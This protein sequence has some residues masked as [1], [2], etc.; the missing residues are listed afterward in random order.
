MVDMSTVTKECYLDFVRRILEHYEVDFPNRIAQEFPFNAQSLGGFVGYIINAWTQMYRITGN[1]SHA[2]KARELL[3]Y[4]SRYPAHNPPG[5]KTKLS[6][7][8]FV[9][10]MLVGG[11][12]ILRDSGFVTAEEEAPVWSCIYDMVNSLVDPYVKQGKEKVAERSHA[13]NHPTMDMTLAVETAQ[14]FP[15][16]PDASKWMEWGRFVLD[17]SFNKPP[18][19]DV[20]G[21]SATWFIHTI[22]AAELLGLTQDFYA[23]PYTRYY[24]Q[25]FRDLLAPTGQ[26]P[27]FGDTSI[28]GDWSKNVA[29]LEKAAS[30]YRDGS[31]KTAAHRLFQYM[32]PYGPVFG[33][34]LNYVPSEEKLNWDRKVA[35]EMRAAGGYLAQ[36]SGPPDPREFYS[37][38]N[39]TSWRSTYGGTL[40]TNFSLLAY[41][42]ADDSVA[43]APIPVRDVLYERRAVLRDGW[44]P[45][46][47]YLCY[48]LEDWTRV[49]GHGEGN[50]VNLLCKWGSMLLHE[51]E[52][53]WKQERYHN[54]VI[55]K[56][57]ISDS[58]LDYI[59][60]PDAPF[61]VLKVRP[62]ERRARVPVF[63]P[64]RDAVFLRS[65]LDQFQ[66]TL[67]KAGE[68]VY[69]FDYLDVKG[70]YTAACL[71]HTQKIVEQ[72]GNAYRTRI[73]DFIW[74][75]R[76][77]RYQNPGEGELLIIF[78]K[79]TDTGF[80]KE[81]RA[82]M[83]E[84]AVY[85]LASD[86]FPQGLAFSTVLFPVKRADPAMHVALNTETLKPQSS[87]S[88]SYPGADGVRLRLNGKTVIVCCK[89]VDSIGVV[90]YGD[91]E[92]DADVLYLKADSGKL[93]ASA[94]NVSTLRYKGETLL[95]KRER[96][97]RFETSSQ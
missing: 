48:G 62:P 51:S 10:C 33:G 77:L 8:P 45:E 56:E 4:W 76:M 35:E 38:E 74:V 93:Q 34:E 59:W 64:M 12:K 97:G 7:G 44:S 9:S 1:V 96:Q 41:L 82:E 23:Y 55:Y 86:T 2:R 42:W 67:V 63:A 65:R 84:L 36:V 68:A 87:G 27:D 24:F 89:N 31:Y 13:W 26:L 94:V 32:A 50:A 17:Q 18:V 73:D 19:E 61:F 43:E 79:A 95:S 21:Y 39:L 80:K 49:H 69:V 3:L 83:D 66:R 71:W 5:E 25:Y 47:S 81:I 78:P 40:E 52:Y 70:A 30:V 46:D 29:I 16:H 75:W 14:I 72:T 58:P 15:D 90:Q 57:G 28:F 85:Q 91:V 37:P 20:T 6:V 92:S 22:R 11:L 54:R 88:D 53:S 60:E